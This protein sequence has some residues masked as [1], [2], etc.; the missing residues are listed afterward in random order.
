MKS[1]LKQFIK[2]EL[3][4]ILKTDYYGTDEQIV[5]EKII[6]NKT[7]IK[8]KNRESIEEY[9]LRIYYGI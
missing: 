6:L 3:N 7:N 8:M 1:M 9:Y 5:N 4:K 2:S